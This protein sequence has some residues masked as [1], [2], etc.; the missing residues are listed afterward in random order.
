MFDVSEQFA[1]VYVYVS[2]TV[3][4]WNWT[5]GNIPKLS[6]PRLRT[7]HGQSVLSCDMSQGIKYSV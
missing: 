3:I 5:N 7:F 4:C 1:I 2:Y 6:K